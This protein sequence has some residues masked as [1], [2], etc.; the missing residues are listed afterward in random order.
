MQATDRELMAGITARDTRAFAELYDRYAPRLLGLIV[1]ILGHQRLA[2]DLLQ[3]VFAEIWRRA[4]QY[5]PMLG[6]PEVWLILVTRAR[7]VDQLRR[8]KRDVPAGLNGDL[9]RPGRVVEDAAR[10]EECHSTREAVAALPDEQRDAI[11]LAFF[12]GLSYPQIAELRALPLGT[13]KTR[14][15]LGMR[16]LREQIERQQGVPTR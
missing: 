16:K 1:K 15:R 8:G 5:N 6:T 9:A 10:R 14:I 4:G 2:E 12:H 3:E 13:V 11:L 7:A